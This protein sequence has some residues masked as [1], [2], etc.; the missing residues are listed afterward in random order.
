MRVITLLFLALITVAFTLFTVLRTPSF[1]KLAGRLAA[2][3][4]SGKLQVKV[5]ISDLRISDL[6]AVNIGGLQ[7]NDHHGSTLLRLEQLRIRPGRISLRDH[8]IAVKSVSLSDGGFYLRHYEDD[9]A[10]NLVRLLDSIIPAA[11]GE[12]K[13]AVTWT[14]RCDK[15]TLDKLAFGFTDER[16]AH[17]PDR[18]DFTDLGFAE[19]YAELSGISVIGD[20]ITADF[21][22]FSCEEKSG[23][24]LFG[25]Y[26]HARV[27]A[28]GIRT[29]NVRIATNRSGLDLDLDLLYNGWD[30]L[31]YFLDSVYISASIRSSLLTAGDIGYFA[32]ELYKM[33]DPVMVSGDIQGFV[34]DFNARDLK[35]KFGDFTDFEGDLSMRGLP[36]FN[37]T[38]IKLDIKR[39]L[40]TPG[41]LAAFNLPLENPNLPVP[42]PVRKLG[43]TS[44]TGRFEGMISNFHADLGIRSDLG[45]IRVK[46]DFHQDTLT[47]KAYYSGD[48]ACQNFNAGK[49]L[50]EQDLGTL[51]LD[52][53][54]EGSGLEPAELELVLSGWIENLI[55]KN[56]HYDRIVIGGK[57]DSRSYNGRL[58]VMDPSLSLL[59]DG[60]VDFNPEQPLMNFSLELVR[61][62]FFDLNLS[63]RSEDMELGARI[64]GDFSGLGL[65]TFTGKLSVEGLAYIE[66]GNDYHL[67]LLEI[68]REKTV[69]GQDLLTLRSDFV[70]ADIEGEFTS[71]ELI[72]E[73]MDFVMARSADSTG[74]A[75]DPMVD[76][77]VNFDFRLKDIAPV[78]EIFLPV[79]YVSPGSQ[80][81]G[82]FDRVR[83]TLDLQV[84][85]GQIIAAGITFNDVSINAYTRNKRLFLEN[86][87]SSVVLQENADTTYLGLDNFSLQANTRSDTIEFAI[88]WDNL[89]S[90]APNRALINGFLRFPSPASLEGGITGANANLGGDFWQVNDDNLILLDSGLVRIQNLDISK[91]SEHFIV[92][93]ALTSFAG[94]TLSMT[95]DQWSL[96]NF[97]PLIQPYSLDLDGIINGRIGIT[98]SDSIPSLFAGINITDFVF[99]QV[100]FG[101]ADL[102]TRW[103]DADS[104]LT[105]KLEIFSKGPV[106]DRYRI[107]DV[108]GS[109]FPFGKTR[110]FDFSI[111]SQNL[112]I[113]VLKPL[114]TSFSSNIGGYATGN[115]TLSGTNRQPL[116]LGSLKLQRAELKVDYLNVTYS[117]SNE[118]RFEENFIRFE[119][120]LVY[121]PFTNK[122][123]LTGGIRHRY[124]SDLRL[125]LSIKPEQLLGFDLNRYQ[126]SVFY[127]KAFATGAVRLSGPFENIQID[128]DV[129]TE[130]GTNVVIPINYSV[131]VSQGDFIVFTGQGEAAGDS[132]VSPQVVGV[133]LNIGMSVT[134]DADIEIVLPG[135]IG[136]VKATGSGDLRLG[137]DPNGYLTMNGAYQIQTGLF[138]FSLEQLVSRRFDILEGSRISWTGDINDA[139]VNLVARYRLRTSLDGLGISMIDPEAAAQKVIVFTDIRM[140]GSL[141][142]PNLS[143]GI[144]FPNL[145][146][147]T[148]QTVYAVLDTNDLA[149][150]NQQAISLLVLGSFSSTGTGGTNPVNAAAIVSS[151]LSNMLSQISNDFNIGINYVPGDQVSDEQLELALSTQLLDNRLIIDG[152]IDVSGSNANTQKTS[153]IVG[154]FNLEY[155]LT[156]DGRF[157]VKAFNRSNDLSL[158]N[159]YSPYTQGV[160]LFY[161][162]EFSHVREFFSRNPRSGPENDEKSSRRNK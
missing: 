27:S 79:L 55:Y 30:Q 162:K 9:D 137:V 35:F 120:A 76:G 50:G 152:N 7:V 84:A 80:V 38:M 97:N 156:P 36:D 18:M 17:T 95:F 141:F 70:D 113:S 73:L 64:I 121:D 33:N 158:F 56:H 118:V 161:R 14:V 103:I 37:A 42:E 6:L 52:L 146:E 154:D 130:K 153:S 40:T 43:F 77:R 134:R 16:K 99:N 112:N 108:R 127:G 124:F 71:V 115:L 101:E 11:S 58:L 90:L 107:L 126:N 144:G 69:S 1:Q 48:L 3:Y 26:G 81:S 53:E 51:D 60:L 87:I 75:P 85:A 63:D 106:T 93:G 91:G 62:R 15:L 83:R 148:K 98:K 140:T 86:K 123:T 4:L 122:A 139:E 29:E 54:F 45:R 117:I 34:R 96:A 104:S 20:S 155:K 89:D 116:L 143:F 13:P 2:D 102:R 94:D 5:L 111:A 31:G 61:A 110:N 136:Y 65:E 160:G 151:T 25:F 157:R 72:R 44:V 47:K 78:T 125:D 142:N 129:K 105:L 82:T 100:Y 109:Y 138:V 19:I 57:V 32:P 68:T 59:F 119:E 39:L 10:L 149:L 24:D 12:D 66:N 74:T 128:V 67:D 49:L 46:S 28:S 8:L 92:D 23:F 133:G 132:L 147:Q 145:Q 131:D 135:N 41:D 114:L 150:M 22:Y 21:N 159:D 88:R